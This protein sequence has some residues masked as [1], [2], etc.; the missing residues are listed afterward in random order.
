MVATT[1]SVEFP[2]EDG[3]FYLCEYRD[4]TKLR[5]SAGDD[6]IGY[7]QTQHQLSHT[8]TSQSPAGR[9]IAV[10]KVIR[11]DIAPN[12][13][14]RIGYARILKFGMVVGTNKRCKKIMQTV[15]AR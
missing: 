6:Q 3:S 11:A 15:V 4:K 9:A 13:I 10:V 14:S 12:G 2:S 5:I 7:L 1:G 8:S